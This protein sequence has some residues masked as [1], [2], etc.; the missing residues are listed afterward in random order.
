[1]G[2]RGRSEED[3]DLFFRHWDGIASY[4]HPENKFT[5]GLVEALNTKIRILQRRAYGYRDEDD[6]KLK[7]VAPFLPPLGRGASNGPL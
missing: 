1:M 5:L 2:G 7:I 3:L 4:C 6:L